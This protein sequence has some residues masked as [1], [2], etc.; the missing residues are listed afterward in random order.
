MKFALFFLLAVLSFIGTLA[1]ILFLTGNLN[2]AALERALSQEPD[3]ATAAG[4]APDSLRS[5]ADE[6]KKK[7][8]ELL[9]RELRLKEKE[10]QL[11]KRELEL[12]DLK[13]EIETMQSEIQQTLGE[14]EEA[15]KARI[16]TV[17]ITVAAMKADAA[18]A[19]LKGMEVE[20]V[21]EILKKIPK[22]KDRG[23]IVEAMEPERATRVLSALQTRPL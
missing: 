2:K 7:E 14:E 5:L 16:E 4:D 17:A 15:R 23:K 19:A 21:A 9:K 18:A 10:A 12:E 6:F 22:E 3:F 13:K 20:E 1:L 8:Q 11:G